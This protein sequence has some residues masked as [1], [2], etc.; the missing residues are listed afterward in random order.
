MRKT[1]APRGCALVERVDDATAGDASA[2]APAH[3][4]V[5]AEVE[6][7]LAAI[8]PKGEAAAHK[9]VVLDLD[10]ARALAPLVGSVMA[11][12]AAPLEEGADRGGRSAKGEARLARA[13]VA[14]QVE[15]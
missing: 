15:L 12:V 8:V 6:L 1:A 2:T 5:V 9:G 7:G 4:V 11:R 10:A 13:A 3:I 14:A